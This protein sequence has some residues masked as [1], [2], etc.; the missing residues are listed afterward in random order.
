MLDVSAEQMQDLEEDIKNFMLSLTDEQKT[1]ILKEILDEKFD[2]L[3]YDVDT[4]NFWGSSSSRR[5]S[6]FGQEL[7]EGLKTKITETISDRIMEK[8]SMMELI[9]KVQ[10][11]VEN[12]FEDYLRES[13]I[14]KMMKIILSPEEVSRIT[15][16]MINQ[17]R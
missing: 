12:R 1:T 11:Q 17:M 10:E 3:Y 14:E 9:K 6:Q 15:Q 8:D 13:L 2:T 4:S 7:S 16:N 5:L